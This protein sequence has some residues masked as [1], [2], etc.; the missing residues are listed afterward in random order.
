MRERNLGRKCPQLF[1]KTL[2]KASKNRK[3][4]VSYFSIEQYAAKPGRIFNETYTWL[5]ILITGKV[6]APHQLNDAHTF[7]V[8]R[9]F[10][11]VSVSLKMRPGLAA[12]CSASMEGGKVVL[13]HVKQE[14]NCKRSEAPF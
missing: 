2:H 1:G 13:Q 8:I 3:W 14:Q 12:Y 11:Q 4:T 10:S 7:P 9:I 5:K 6:C